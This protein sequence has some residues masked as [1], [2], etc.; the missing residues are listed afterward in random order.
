M[1]K[2]PAFYDEDALLVLDWA[3]KNTTSSSP[4]DIV[5]AIET[6][7]RLEYL[8]AC[9]RYLEHFSPFSVDADL[10]GRAAAVYTRCFAEGDNFSSELKNGIDL[11]SNGNSKEGLSIL[12]IQFQWFIGLNP[13]KQ[14]NLHVDTYS[15]ITAIEILYKNSNFDLKNGTALIRWTVDHTYDPLTKEETILHAAETTAR[16]GDYVGALNILKHRFFET[17]KNGT[18][19]KLQA[20][21]KALKNWQVKTE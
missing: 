1:I 5:H 19:N 15:M 18:T 2:A 6:A 11:C 21:V 9:K 10:K 4:Q 7:E 13:T 16:M 20:R 12:T 17:Y 14:D 8:T 3:V